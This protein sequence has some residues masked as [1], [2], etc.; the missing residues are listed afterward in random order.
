M[1]GIEK[2]GRDY[3]EQQK[4]RQSVVTAPNYSE[5]RDVTNKASPRMWFGLYLAVGGKGK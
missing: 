3:C 4:Y 2:W 1:K 5:N